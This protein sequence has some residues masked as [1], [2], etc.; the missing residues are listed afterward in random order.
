[1]QFRVYPV[2]PELALYV[3]MLWT[4]QGFAE[5]DAHQTIPPDGCMEIILHVSGGVDEMGADGR[6]ARQPRTL[7]VG[8]SRRPSC[9][10]PIGELDILGARLTPAGVRALFDA[11]AR[12][13]IDQTFALESVLDA[14]VRADVERVMTTEPSE[15]LRLFERALVQKVRRR[16]RHDALVARMVAQMEAVVPEQVKIEDFAAA[17]GITRRQL[18]RRFLDAVGMPPQTLSRIVRF[19]HVLAA[20]TDDSPRWTEIAAVCG[21]YDQA[22]LIRDFKHFTGSTPHAFLTRDDPFADVFLPGAS[23]D[24]ASVQYAANRVA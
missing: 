4:V 24:V 22:H 1:M 2:D 18:E 5:G 7:L 23:A 3:R 8:E 9:V 19:Q 14:E 11:P 6:I 16:R 21:Y 17:A 15:R 20:L 12:E 13:L 10:R